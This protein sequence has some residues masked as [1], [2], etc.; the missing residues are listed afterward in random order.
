MNFRLRFSATFRNSK[1]WKFSNFAPL[2]QLAE[3]VTLNHRV[4]EGISRALPKTLPIRGTSSNGTVFATDLTGPAT[5]E[6]K[7]ICMLFFYSL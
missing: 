2:A 4:N 7:D 5:G 6:E 3:Q 1:I